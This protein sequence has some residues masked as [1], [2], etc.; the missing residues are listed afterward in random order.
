M[1]DDKLLYDSNSSTYIPNS[2]C[3]SITWAG[4][5]DY[6][7]PEGTICACGQ[8]KLKYVICKECGNKKLIFVPI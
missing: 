6:E 4:N 3:H 1:K 5:F 7:I 2:N 8:T